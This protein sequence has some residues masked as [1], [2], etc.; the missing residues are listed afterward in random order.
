MAAGAAMVVLDQLRAALTGKEGHDEVGVF[1]VFRHV[2][3][4]CRCC[5]GVVSDFKTAPLQPPCLIMMC[6]PP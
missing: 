2:T 1:M 5:Y 6:P 4:H 3:S